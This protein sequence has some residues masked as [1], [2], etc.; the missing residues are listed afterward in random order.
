MLVSRSPRDAVWPLGVSRPCAKGSPVA[1]KRWVW[2]QAQVQTKICDVQLGLHAKIRSF[3]TE[4]EHLQL[5]SVRLS[6]PPSDNLED[7]TTKDCYKTCDEPGIRT[8]SCTNP[9]PRCCSA[10]FRTRF[11]S[12]FLVVKA[13]ARTTTAESLLI[14]RRISGL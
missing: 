6:L 5:S 3:G 12:L 4:N 1:M 9:L 11:K 2:V 10:S 7:V 13:A 8:G 14:L